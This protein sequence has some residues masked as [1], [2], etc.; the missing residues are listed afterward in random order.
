M[1]ALG[2]P[3]MPS[4]CLQSL[5]KDSLCGL[6]LCF[7]YQQSGL[8][9]MLWSSDFWVTICHPWR[10]G[11]SLVHR[12]PVMRYGVPSS[13]SYDPPWKLAGWCDYLSFT[14]EKLAPGRL[15]KQAKAIEL[16]LS[17]GQL[18]TTLSLALHWALPFGKA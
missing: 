7:V 17:P 8:G 10:G 4:P 2:S 1:A 14:D 9:W 11:R 13:P 3:E 12:V 18:P 15:R 6:F 16:G 5:E